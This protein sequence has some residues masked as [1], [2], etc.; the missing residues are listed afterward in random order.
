MTR[1]LPLAAFILLPVWLY[2]AMAAYPPAEAVEIFLPAL[3]ALAAGVLLTIAL[4]R[5]RTSG[6][7]TPIATQP[8]WPFGILRDYALGFALGMSLY[9]LD[10]AHIFALAQPYD[11]AVSALLIAPVW[12]LGNMLVAF[13]LRAFAREQ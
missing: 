6:R 8:T 1:H 11:L 7:A 13:M 10:N 2:A 5:R 12:V 9:Q 3:A 4:M